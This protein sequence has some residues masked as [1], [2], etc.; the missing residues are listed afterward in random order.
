MITANEVQRVRKKVLGVTQYEFS[1]MLSFGASS[2]SERTVQ[3]WERDET[4]PSSA[5]ESLIWLIERIYSTEN[6]LIEEINKKIGRYPYLLT[7]ID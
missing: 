5:A 4:S 2:I 7:S 1:L 6:P 3:K